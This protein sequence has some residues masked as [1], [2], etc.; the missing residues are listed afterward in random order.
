M[1]HMSVDTFNV[2]GPADRANHAAMDL[3]KHPALHVP[4]HAGS[5]IPGHKVTIPSSADKLV[6]TGKAIEQAAVLYDDYCRVITPENLLT[7]E[8][9]EV[10]AMLV[11]CLELRRKWLFKPAD[12]EVKKVWRSPGP[13]GGWGV[14]HG[15]YSMV[16]ARSACLP[17]F[18]ICS[19]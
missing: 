5:P 16:P 18:M 17:L 14:V 2:L 7:E 4:A 10:C 1:N 8:T 19:Q 13:C 12:S 9:E 15:R 3:L 11:E 6:D